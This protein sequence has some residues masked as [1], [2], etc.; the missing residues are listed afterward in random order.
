MS[1]P[2][3]YVLLIPIITSTYNTNTYATNFNEPTHAKHLQI[4]SNQFNSNTINIDFTQY[5]KVNNNILRTTAKT[6]KYKLQQHFHG[7]PIFGATLVIEQDNNND[8]K[9][10]IFGKYYNKELI[11]NDID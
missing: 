7:I 1:S 2:L 6:I 9:H 11:R 3:I 5:N 4:I 10:P 8:I